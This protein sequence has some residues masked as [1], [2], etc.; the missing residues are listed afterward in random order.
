MA[1]PLTGNAMTS[2][3]LKVTAKYAKCTKIKVTLRK[4]NR[5]S[6][7]SCEEALISRS[8]ERTAFA[9]SIMEGE[10]DD[11]ER[12]SHYGQFLFPEISERRR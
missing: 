2:V 6:V 11:N 9:V 5:D 10:N 3:R 1:I 4:K 8:K 7:F 12:I